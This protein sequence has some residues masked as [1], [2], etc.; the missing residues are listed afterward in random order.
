VPSSA[1]LPPGR[2]SCTALRRRLQPK[3]SL[4]SQ[5]KALFD[6][7]GVELDFS[8]GALKAIA[9]Q[10][11]SKGTGAR[12]LRNIVERV[13]LDPMYVLL[14]AMLCV[15]QAR[16]T[17]RR[18]GRGARD[19]PAPIEHGPCRARRVPM[20][21]GSDYR[22]RATLFVMRNLVSCHDMAQKLTQT[23]A[24]AR[25]EVPGSDVQK[26]TISEEVVNG[27]AEAVYVQGKAERDAARQEEADAAAESEAEAEAE[28]PIAKSG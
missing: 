4:S 1:H 24:L 28:A 23:T 5:Y 26:V 7:D 10:A 6:Y 12:G 16:T 25:Y 11:L 14:R 19:N 8:E 21:A 13:L 3:N 2:S 20:R 9:G 15:C 17:V 27:D 22:A 18:L